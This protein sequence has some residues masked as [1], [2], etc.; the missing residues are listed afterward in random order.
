MNAKKI[1][2]FHSYLNEHMASNEDLAR[3]IEDLKVIQLFLLKSGMPPDRYN[4]IMNLFYVLVYTKASSEEIES[5]LVI[6][7]L[8]IKQC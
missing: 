5:T 6:I 4:G 2:E 8:N 1:E 7:W 3:L